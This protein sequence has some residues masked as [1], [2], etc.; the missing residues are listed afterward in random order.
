MVR[1]NFGACNFFAR[2]YET[3]ANGDTAPELQTMAPSGIVDV[4]PRDIDLQ[5][6][7]KLKKFSP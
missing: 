4:F 2:K 5:N 3:L 7:K 1:I 6:V